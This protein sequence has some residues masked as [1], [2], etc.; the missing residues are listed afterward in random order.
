MATGTWKWFM[1]L[2]VLVVCVYDAHIP[3]MQHP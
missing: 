3:T 2:A 1:L